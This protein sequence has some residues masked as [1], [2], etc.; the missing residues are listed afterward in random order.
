MLDRCIY[1]KK[2]CQNCGE[3]LQKWGKNRD[4]SQRYFCKNCQQTKTRKRPELTQ[5]NHKKIFSGWLVGKQ[6]LTD[7]SDKYDVSIRTLIRW[8]TLFWSEEP[9]PGE[10]NISNQVLIIDGKYIEKLATVLVACVTRKVS[11][12]SFTQ[13]ENYASWLTFFNTLVHNPFAIV[14]DGQKGMLKAIKERFPRVIIQRCQFHVMKYCLSKLT[15]NPESKAAQELRN[16]VLEISKIKTKENFSIWLANYKIWYQ[17]H[18]EFLKEKTYQEHN[19]TPTGRKRWHYTHGR[20]HAAYSHLKNAFPNLFQYLKYPKIP[21]TT[22]FVEGAIN[23]PMQEKLRNHRG[24]KLPKR[25][26]LIAHYLSIKQ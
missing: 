25:R 24:L 26:I 12:W 8:F 22:N 14:C 21:N 19:L 17:D 11:S 20:L 18:Y 3:K 6:S 7:F 4:G 9:Q 2:W 10:T 5:I 16:I 1:E 13:R 15:Q 23:A